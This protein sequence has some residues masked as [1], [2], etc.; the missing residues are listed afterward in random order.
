MTK[1]KKLYCA[2]HQRWYNP[3]KGPCPQC[4]KGEPGIPVTDSLG[5]SGD[6]PL[7]PQANVY[8]LPADS[9]DGLPLD[10]EQMQI[11]QEELRRRRA[12]AL[13]RMRMV[14][15]FNLIMFIIFF[16]VFFAIFFI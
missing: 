2:I 3:E 13:K 16:I 11:Y 15:I 4:E 14:R 9:M 8:Y 10:P 7:E 1:V 12:E 5:H 6:L